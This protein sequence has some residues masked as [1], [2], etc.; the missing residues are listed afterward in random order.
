MKTVQRH[1]SKIENLWTIIK[2]A[3]YFL[4]LPCLFFFAAAS[5]MIYLG[6][7]PGGHSDPNMAGFF[8]LVW[9][10]LIV[11]LA[12]R[13]Y[14]K[15]TRRHQ[16]KKMVALLTSE[17]RFSPQKQHQVMDA[18]R[19]KYL[20]IDTRSGNILYIHIVK[21]GIVD[22]IGLTSRD[23]TD[24]ELEGST[25]RILTKNPEVPV[26]SINAHP[27]VT[28]ELFNTLGAMSHKSYTESFPQE[29]W[30]LHVSLQSRFVEFEHD[31]VVP[32]AS[33]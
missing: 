17:V 3:Y 27:T 14:L 9:V 32:Q 20:G 18:G 33:N 24:R 19:G 15:V 10:A 23:W 21:K 1:D 8:V 16:L 28:K 30:P 22:V 25:L 12:F 4:A 29:P 31:V 13:R 5:F 26:L 7:Q 6:K 2:F 11:P